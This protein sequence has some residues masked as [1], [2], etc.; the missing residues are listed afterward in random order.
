[1]AAIASIDFD[2]PRTRS[3]HSHTCCRT[4]VKCH[5]TAAEGRPFIIEVKRDWAPLGADRFLKLVESGYFTDVPF[6]RVVPGFLT[7]FGITPDK[8]LRKYWR[9][10]G[11]I[12]DD[13]SQ[14]MQIKR[15]YLSF[16]GGGPNTRDMQLFIALAGAPHGGRARAGRDVCVREWLVYPLAR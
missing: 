2:S 5:T 13:P 7:Q 4:L 14:H 10:Q 8:A 11:P 9:E 15:G 1:M 6:F 3:I 16:A 12:Q